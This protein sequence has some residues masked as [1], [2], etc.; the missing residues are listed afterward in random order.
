MRIKNLIASGA[1]ALALAFAAPSTASA[2]PIITPVSAVV[3]LGGPGSGFIEDTFDRVFD[4]TNP[5]PLDTTNLNFEDL[6]GLKHT[7]RFLGYEWFSG[8]NQT[9]A[10]VTYDLG[11]VMQVDRLALWN[12]E[13]SGAG[14]LDLSYSIDGTS[15]F[16]LATGLKP[17]DHIALIGEPPAGISLEPPPFYGADLFTFALTDARYVRFDMSNCATGNDDYNACAIGEVAFSNPVPEPATLLFVGS[18]LAG[19][20]LRRR[21]RA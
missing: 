14:T 3:G 21:R 10:Q 15:W 12:E 11:A 2:G 7:S 18:G 19:L 13:S 8:E 16:A 4:H 1:I 5:V 9:T 6:L 17:T 20:A